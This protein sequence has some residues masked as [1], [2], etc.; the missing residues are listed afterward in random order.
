M[1]AG[2]VLMV[3]EKFLLAVAPALS[4][5]KTVKPAVPGVV[6]VPLSR[7]LAELM[8]RPAGRLPLLT[9]QT[10]GG[11]PPLSASCCE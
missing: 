10:K 1:I 2:D 9:L 3:R 5:S 7:P 4:V 8:E 11:V 6:G